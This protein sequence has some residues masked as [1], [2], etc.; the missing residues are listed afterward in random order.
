MWISWD[1]YYKCLKI[2]LRRRSLLSH[3]YYKNTVSFILGTNLKWSKFVYNHPFF[4]NVAEVSCHFTLYFNHIMRTIF[5]KFTTSKAYKL[6]LILSQ[7]IFSGLYNLLKHLRNNYLLLLIFFPLNLLSLIWLCFGINK[8]ILKLVLTRY[9]HRWRDYNCEHCS[10][11]YCSYK[12]K[13]SILTVCP[14]LIE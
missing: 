4:I 1:I 13:Q 12:K 11:Q 14:Q 3:F 5:P 8:L 6:I 10:V 9:V 2:Q 7:L